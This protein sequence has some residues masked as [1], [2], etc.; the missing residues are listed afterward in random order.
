MSGRAGL[1]TQ[2]HLSFPSLHRS[3]GKGRFSST[4]A[5]LY[6]YNHFGSYNQIPAD[7]STTEHLECI[8][9]GSF[10]ALLH[11]VFI[12]TESLCINISYRANWSEEFIDP[13]P[14]DLAF[15]IHSVK[16]LGPTCILQ[17]KLW[18]FQMIGLLPRHYK[19]RWKYLCTDL[20]GLTEMLV[21]KER[22]R[23]LFVVCYWWVSIAFVS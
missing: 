23:R 6:Y 17:S 21:E 22:C 11:L 16:N 13:G 2:I 4:S 9:H 5:T 8:K 3:W 14:G 19:E 7:I 18:H 10:L 1:G 15:K 20:E 12:Q